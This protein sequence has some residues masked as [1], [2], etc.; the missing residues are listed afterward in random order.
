MN[1]S[2][3]IIP[4][5]GGSKRIER[6]NIKLFLNKPIISY[7]IQTALSLFDAVMVSTDDEAIAD[8]ARGCDA[9]IF[10]PPAW[11]HSDTAE[12]EDVIAEV[13]SHTD[14]GLVC[15]M[16]PTS[17]FADDQG[18]S[19][20]MLAVGSGTADICYAV[21]EFEYPIQRALRMNEYGRVSFVDDSWADSN[22]QDLPKRY[23]DAGQYYVFEAMTFHAKWP[24]KRLLEWDSIGIMYKRTGVHDIDTPEDWEIAEMKYERLHAI[25]E[26]G[27]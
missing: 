3:C 11:V 18:I 25:K 12:T 20:A 4:A 17:V 27:L 16:Y 23:H 5:R 1:K 7:P 8:V 6:K 9:S 13:L 2:L 15:V 19:A 26:G 14:A 24:G 10:N 21:A 22:S